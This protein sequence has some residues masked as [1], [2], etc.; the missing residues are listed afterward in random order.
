MTLLFL[1]LR[2]LQLKQNNQKPK[3]KFKQVTQR[4]KKSLSKITKKRKLN[5]KMMSHKLKKVKLMN[6]Q[7]STKQ[8]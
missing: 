6:K 7:S 3:Q 1:M 4:S 2:I 8:G 5:L